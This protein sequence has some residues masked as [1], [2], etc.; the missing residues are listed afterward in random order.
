[1]STA[2]DNI[3]NEYECNI[4]VLDYEKNDNSVYD[5]LLQDFMSLV[6]SFSGKFYKLRSLRHEQMLLDLAQDNVN[7]KININE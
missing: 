2:I 1:M 3:F 5:E 7:E 6:A 4:I